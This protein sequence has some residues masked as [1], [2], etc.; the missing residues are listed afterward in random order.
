VTLAKDPVLNGYIHDQLQLYAAWIESSGT[1]FFLGYTDHGEDHLNRV[2]T[3]C[4][5]LVPDESWPLL[6]SSDAACLILSVLLHDSAMHLTPASFRR[7]LSNNEQNKIFP[8]LDDITWHRCGAL[9][10]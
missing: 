3:A 2:L 4:D 8:T 1:P 7:L 9:T 10:N 6:T 5:W